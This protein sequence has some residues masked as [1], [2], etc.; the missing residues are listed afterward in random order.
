MKIGENLRSPHRL[1]FW[2]ALLTGF[3]F[4]FAAVGIHASAQDYRTLLSEHLSEASVFLDDTSQAIDQCN[5]A[6]I[7]CFVNPED[8]ATRIDQAN[9]GLRQVVANLS[10]MEV[11]EP[12]AIDHALLSLGFGNVTNGLTL[13]TT[14]LRSKDP[15]TLGVAADLISDGNNQIR[16]AVNAIFAPPPPGLDLIQLLTYIVI[17]AAI[18]LSL[19]LYALL[20]VA[21]QQGRTYIEKELA[22][23]PECGEVL[24]RWRT[25]RTRQI[26]DWQETHLRSHGTE[27]GPSRRED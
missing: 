1:Q 6:L 13:Y 16:D 14:G 10:A 5:R 11:P 20:R 2:C 12:Y 24:D 27:T 19:L 8:I 18:G 7:G 4:A 9:Q 17:A 23:C 22:T 26:R 21:R 3:A 15:G 25:F